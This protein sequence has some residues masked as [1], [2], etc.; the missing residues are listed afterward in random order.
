MSDDPAL[1]RVSTPG[2]REHVLGI[3]LLVAMGEAATKVVEREGDTALLLS[4][5]MS[6]AAQLAGQ[7]FGN[8]LAAGVARDQD[9]RRA[10]ETAMTNFRIGIQTGRDVLLREMAERVGGRA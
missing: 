4:I 9:R 5:A 3:E 1:L 6:S 10:G 7:C 8:L 2:Q